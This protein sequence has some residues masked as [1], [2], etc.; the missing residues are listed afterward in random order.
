[1]PQALKREVSC[2][3]QQVAQSLGLVS[4]NKISVMGVHGSAT[5]SVYDADLCLPR[6]GWGTEGINLIEL[7]VPNTTSYH[8]IIGMDI[9]GRGTLHF[10]YGQPGITPGVCTFC[11]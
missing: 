3:A 6:I 9:L 1:M 11:I 10:N 4:R 8:A 5:R 7:D 2:I